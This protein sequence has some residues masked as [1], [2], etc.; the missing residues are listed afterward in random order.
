MFN[1]RQIGIWPCRDGCSGVPLSLPIWT[2]CNLPWGFCPSMR[3]CSS[4]FVSLMYKSGH[5]SLHRT[6]YTI[7][8]CVLVLDPLGVIVLVC[9][10]VWNIWGHCVCWKSS[11]G[12]QI[13]QSY[14]VQ[15]D[16]IVVFVLL[17]F[18]SGVSTSFFCSGDQ[19]TGDHRE[20]WKWSRGQYNEM[21]QGIN[22]MRIQQGWSIRL[23]RATSLK[24]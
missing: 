3:L 13:L 9:W 12:F 21:H 14:T 11:G 19:V 7:L 1:N 8:L 20:L 17:A 24:R 2:I 5:S 18:Y 15:S 6:V 22:I 23:R 10:K 16:D 4:C